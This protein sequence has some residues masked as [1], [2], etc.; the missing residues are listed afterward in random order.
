MI[1]LDIFKDKARGGTYKGGVGCEKRE[2]SRVAQGLD[3]S[4]RKI[5]SSAENILRAGARE[6]I[7]LLIE[8][9]ASWRT[10]HIY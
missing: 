1:I 8:M 7:L 9:L 4:N 2:E 6:G 5:E 3:L 10:Y